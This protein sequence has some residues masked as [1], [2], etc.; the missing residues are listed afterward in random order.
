MTNTISDDTKAS[1]G[2]K[3]DPTKKSQVTE[4][5]SKG[6]TP[7]H[8]ESDRDIKILSSNELIDLLVAKCPPLADERTQFKSMIGLVGYPNVGKSSTINALVGAKRVSV[9]SMPG[10]TKHFQTIHL[11]GRHCTLRLPGPCIP[12]IRHDKGRHGVQR[13]PTNRS[14]QRVHRPC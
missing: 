9:G 10:K 14:A 12:Y 3:G 4:D 1:E 7:E 6:T 5:F 11:L 2:Q 13:C 8:K